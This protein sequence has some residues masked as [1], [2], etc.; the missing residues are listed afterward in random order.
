MNSQ[1]FLD[2]TQSI[3]FFILVIPIYVGLIDA[4]FFV[5]TGY[6]YT[7]VAWTWQRILAVLIFY[8]IRL[9]HVASKK[10]KK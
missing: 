4:F 6:T 9:A 7:G 10:E 2:F 5:I 3:F 8:F 1:K